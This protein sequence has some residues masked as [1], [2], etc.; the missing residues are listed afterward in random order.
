MLMLLS[1][2]SFFSS[3]ES[4]R[5]HL[6]IVPLAAY[7]KNEKDE[8]KRSRSKRLFSVISSHSFISFP[9]F[10]R[11]VANMLPVCFGAISNSQPTRCGHTLRGV[12][13]RGWRVAAPLRTLQRHK[14]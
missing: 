10:F 6:C 5:Y 1:F 11:D 13:C 3:F 4:Q 9:A 12:H 2:P 14:P 7:E 8:E